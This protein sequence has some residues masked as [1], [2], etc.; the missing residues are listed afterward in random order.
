MSFKAKKD[1]V[2]NSALTTWSFRH[3]NDDVQPAREVNRIEDGFLRSAGLGSNFTAPGSLVV[4]TTGL[5]F[6]PTTASDLETALN[7]IDLT[8]SDIQ[9]AVKLRQRILRARLSKY[10]VGL[11]VKRFANSADNKSVLVVGQVE[12][13]ES[14]QRGCQDIADNESLLKAVRAAE[15]GSYLSLIHI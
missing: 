13:D 7:T 15:Q 8:P 12:D 6:D 14:I 1:G 11:N 3:F 10:N 2:K 5:Y 9:R 4:D